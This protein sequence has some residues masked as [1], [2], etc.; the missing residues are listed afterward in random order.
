[1]QCFQLS[2]INTGATIRQK[3]LVVREYD[4]LPCA[5]AKP[6]NFLLRGEPTTTVLTGEGVVEDD[7]LFSEVSVAL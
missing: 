1:L 6:T 5:A 7:D 4:Y 3:R 2:G